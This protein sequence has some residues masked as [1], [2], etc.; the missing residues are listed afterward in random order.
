M[1]QLLILFLTG[2]AVAVSGADQRDERQLQ[3]AVRQLQQM[4]ISDRPVMMAET[5]TYAVY[6]AQTGGF[7]VV[8]KQDD[9][10][11][12]GYSSTVSTTGLT[13]PM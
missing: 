7:V 11:V 13:C 8:G 1:R 3:T 4:G 2:I 9:G 6:G 10:Q 5:E 12:L